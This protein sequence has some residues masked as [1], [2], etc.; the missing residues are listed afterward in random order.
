MP[1]KVYARHVRPGKLIEEL[2]AQFPSWVTVGADGVRRA[3]FT[4]E[5]DGAGTA[6][7]ITWNTATPEASVDAVVAAH[8]DTTPAAYETAIIQRFADWADLRDMADQM[9]TRATQIETQMN[10]TPTNQQVINAVRD[11]AIG[12]RRLTKAVSYLAVQEAG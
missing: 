3:H 8:D 10:G 7:A 5:H 12:V 2:M 1:R 9:I 4:L 11:L 6:V